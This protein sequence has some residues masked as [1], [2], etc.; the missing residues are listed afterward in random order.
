[1]LKEGVSQMDGQ[2]LAYLKQKGEGCDYTIGCAQTMITIKANS[3]D[4]AII[5]LKRVID[6]EYHDDLELNDALL[7]ECPPYRIDLED[8][9]DNRNSRLKSEKEQKEHER[10][11]SEYRRLQQKFNEKK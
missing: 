4:D 6:E 5:E 11:L 7:F 9:Y 10:E 3:F 2:Y 1:M 8:I